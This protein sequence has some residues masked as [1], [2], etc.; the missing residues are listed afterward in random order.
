LKDLTT[1]LEKAES[2][3]RF[4]LIEGKVVRLLAPQHYK[5]PFTYKK[6]GWGSIER[7]ETIQDGTP[8]D[9]RAPKRKR[10]VR[11]GEEEIKTGDC[12]TFKNEKDHIFLPWGTQFGIFKK[13]LLRSLEAQK[14]LR[15]DAAPL[16]LM[17]VYPTWLNIGKIPCESMND[18]NIPEVILETRHTQSGDV[19]VEVFFDYI[20]NRDFSCIVEID[21]EAPMNEEKFVALVKTL[22]TL[23]TIGPSKRGQLS[24]TKITQVEPSIDEL[25][26]L[27]EGEPVIY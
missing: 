5:R 13:S 3:D 27:S 4:Y 1:E 6:S 23:D 15:Y 18:K 24:I 20:E 7:L 19:M 26:K 8:A 17:K 11:K 22:N 21:S 10:R 9:L 2:K 14:K 16:G 25:K 12:W